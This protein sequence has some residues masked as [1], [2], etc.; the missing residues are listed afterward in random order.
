MLSSGMGAGE[1][2]SLTPF[3][4][5]GVL[6]LPVSSYDPWLTAPDDGKIS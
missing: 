5:D 4:S 2:L 6:M 1:V 3:F